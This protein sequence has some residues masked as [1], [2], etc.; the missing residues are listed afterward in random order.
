MLSE[1]IRVEP[2][3]RLVPFIRKKI[4]HKECVCIEKRPYKDT[5]RRQL[6]ASQRESS[7]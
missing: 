5:V 1:I 2:K 6:F 3:S 4:R 7:H